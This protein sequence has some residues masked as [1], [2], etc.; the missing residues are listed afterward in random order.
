M[1][2]T[3]KE[4]RD[5]VVQLEMRLDAIMSGDIPQEDILNGNETLLDYLLVEIDHISRAIQLL[6]ERN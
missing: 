1:I 3:L 2:T 5:Y 4:L 6:E